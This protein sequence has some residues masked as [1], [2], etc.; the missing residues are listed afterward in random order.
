ME[1]SPSFT[2]VETCFAALQQLFIGLEDWF[3]Q[4]VVGFTCLARRFTGV[5]ETPEAS[6]SNARASIGISRASMV[7]SWN[8][9]DSSLFASDGEW[10]VVPAH[11]GFAACFRGHLN[12][13]V[14]PIDPAEA[15]LSGSRRDM[16][17]QRGT[18]NRSSTVEAVPLSPIER[19]HATAGG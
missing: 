16:G 6:P 19:R 8:L 2:L 15:A 12:T 10:N 1:C 13:G 17:T 9:I 5:A 4:H 7:V 3:I 14:S 18:I 11:A